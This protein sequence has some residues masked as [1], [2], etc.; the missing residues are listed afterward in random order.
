MSEICCVNMLYAILYMPYICHIYV[1]D[2]ISLNSDYFAWI[3]NPS[4]ISLTLSRKPVLVTTNCYKYLHMSWH[5]YCRVMCKISLQLF[6]SFSISAF[7]NFT[8]IWI[9]S[10]NTGIKLGPVPYNYYGYP[11]LNIW[12][13][14]WK[15]Q[16]V[17]W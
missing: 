17:S 2:L 11:L 3:S 4:E 10:E 8:R 13:Y 6:S 16:F 14:I 9:P 5:I 7:C 15:R 1:M 12:P